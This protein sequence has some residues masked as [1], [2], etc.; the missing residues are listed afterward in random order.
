MTES[1]K[2]AES[3]Y[4]SHNSVR[5]IA[6]EFGIS[7]SYVVALKNSYECYVKYGAEGNYSVQGH[8][9]LSKIYPPVADKIWGFCDKYS[10]PITKTVVERLADCY[11]STG[12]LTYAA[13]QRKPRPK[14]GAYKKRIKVPIEQQSK[15]EV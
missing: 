11:L 8:L 5:Q 14:T 9:A 1:V 4:N 12:K 6:T 13:A 7:I 10:I 3:V 15:Q 2:L